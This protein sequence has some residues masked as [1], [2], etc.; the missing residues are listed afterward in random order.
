MAKNISKKIKKSLEVIKKISGQYA[1]K[2]IAVA[3]TGGK[4]STVLLH[5]IRKVC[6]GKVPFPVFF[7]DSPGGRFKKT[8]AGWFYQ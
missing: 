3:W 6:K 5:L 8:P 7:N 1:T 4:D 2:K